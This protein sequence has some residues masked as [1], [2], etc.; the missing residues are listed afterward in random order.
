M[1][2][3]PS[4]GRG[5]GRGLTMIW[6]WERYR[7]SR[8]V[9]DNLWHVRQAPV[10]VTPNAPN[11]CPIADARTRILERRQTEDGLGRNFYFV[12]MT[13]LGGQEPTSTWVQ[14]S[15][16]SDGPGKSG[17][18]VERVHVSRI[19][20]YVSPRELERF[21]NE[22][23]RVEAEA[24]AVA[25]RAAK[26]EQV[27][28]RLQKNARAAGGGG[29]RGRGRGSGI[30]PELRATGTG[31][32]RPRGSGRGRG[33]GRSS[34][35]GRGGLASGAGRSNELS[36]DEIVD[37]EPSQ[38]LAERPPASRDDVA[39]TSTES[40]DLPE[41][42]SPRL[43]RSAFVTNS[44]LPL[45]P[46]QSR[47]PAPSR[48]RRAPPELPDFG[49][50]HT[51]AGDFQS[52]SVSNAAKQLQVEDDLD[53]DVIAVE[54]SSSIHSSVHENHTHPAKRRRTASMT[55]QHTLMFPPSSQM[56]DSDSQDDS[57]PADPPSTVRAQKY[58]TMHFETAHCGPAS[59][60]EDEDEAEDEDK[61]KD[62]D[63]DEDEDRDKDEDEDA[64]E[65][66]VSAILEHY[67]DDQGRKFFLV[68]WEGYEDS[69]D[70]LPED[71][72]QGAR[73][74][75]AEYEERV[76]RQKGKRRVWSSASTEAAT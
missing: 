29:G 69:H 42:A 54:A 4:R 15:D 33:R 58:R 74:M 63:K 65:Y 9:Y 76:T 14:S 47:R 52:G 39:E 21:E 1:S 66:V 32:G 34:W 60:G 35:R 50:I 13:Y 27:R 11:D 17:T 5:R 28:R 67:F 49:D 62:E 26:E 31:R 8:S 59:A 6:E 18:E 71:D 56:A 19:L 64:E 25:D 40:D 70:W 24:Q 48:P 45:S 61:N 57:I 51:I 41:P 20:Q 3:R 12:E 30:D 38:A 36:Q 43:M 72:L 10:A 68:K 44:A 75:V 73:E 23:F 22:Q 53:F 46:V 55:P 37:S 16:G 7:P 2:V